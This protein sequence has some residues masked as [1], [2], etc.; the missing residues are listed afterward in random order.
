MGVEP[1]PVPATEANED[2]PTEASGKFQDRVAGDHL[3]VRPCG[4]A[5][6]HERMDIRGEM[7][8][9]A[10]P[11]GQMLPSSMLG[12]IWAGVSAILRGG[13]SCRRNLRRLRRRYRR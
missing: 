12:G 13:A 2:P 11:L 7:G 4:T 3:R 8:S 5:S 10:Q 1:G 9:G 6:V